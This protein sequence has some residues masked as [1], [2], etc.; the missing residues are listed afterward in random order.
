MLFH[1]FDVVPSEF[2]IVGGG[3]ELVVEDN[4]LQGSVFGLDAM[5]CFEGFV[6]VIESEVDDLVW[7]GDE[8]QDTV[9]RNGLEVH[10][11]GVLLVLA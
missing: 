3:E 7:V 1:C 11:F 9:G 8:T 5:D 2:E 6:L 10:N 4:V